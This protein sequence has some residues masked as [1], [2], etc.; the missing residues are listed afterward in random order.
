MMLIHSLSWIQKSL[1]WIV[2]TNPS[3][4]YIRTVL[5]HHD[6]KEYDRNRPNEGTRKGWPYTRHRGRTITEGALL[7]RKGIYLTR[8][9]RFCHGQIN[10]RSPSSKCWILVRI[11][12]NRDL[13]TVTLKFAK[14]TAPLLKNSDWLFTFILRR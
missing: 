13:M 2:Q 1:D 3:Y 6:E 9:S 7:A 12:S 5:V 4:E 14:L 8:Y 10:C 11:D